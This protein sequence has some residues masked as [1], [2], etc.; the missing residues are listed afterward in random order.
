M[1]PSGQTAASSSV[2]SLFGSNLGSTVTSSTA[3]GT[4]LFSTMPDSAAKPLGT[5]ASLFNTKP[6]DNAAKSVGTGASLFRTKPP[7]AGSTLFGVEQGETSTEVKVNPPTPDL[8]PQT[9]L[10]GSISAG[11]SS[12]GSAAGLF[13]SKL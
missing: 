7:S 4:S 9:S 12:N 6:T 10:F 2:P 5:G 3:G 8:Q 1:T 11:T 13:G